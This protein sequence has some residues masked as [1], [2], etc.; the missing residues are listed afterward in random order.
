MYVTFTKPTDGMP[1]D[2]AELH[3]SY[4]LSAFTTEDVV[5]KYEEIV[6]ENPEQYA[7]WPQTFDELP[8]DAQ[9][10]LVRAAARVFEDVSVEMIAIEDSIE[11]RMAELSH[12]Q[13]RRAGEI[14]KERWQHGV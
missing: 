10:A 5:M 7:G 4:V 6:E 8:L 12:D 2:R 13:K 14:V 9:I 3:P 11:E 1:R